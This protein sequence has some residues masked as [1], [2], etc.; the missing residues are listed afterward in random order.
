MIDWENSGPA[1]QG[2]ELACVLFEFARSDPGRARA[3]LDSLLA[4]ARAADAVT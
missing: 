3:L 2:Q 4:D 1:D